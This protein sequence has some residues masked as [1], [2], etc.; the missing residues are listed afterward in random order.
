MVNNNSVYQTVDL[1]LIINGF[2]FVGV[3]PAINATTSW[4]LN[5]VRQFANISFLKTFL[6]LKG[7]TENKD[8]SSI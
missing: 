8:Y 4:L 2:V 7:I 1:F 3:L 6:F 5:L